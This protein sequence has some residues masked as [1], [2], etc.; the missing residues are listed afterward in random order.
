MPIE[1]APSS[2]VINVSESISR[3]FNQLDVIIDT[4][5]NTTRSSVIKVSNNLIKPTD[6]V[7]SPDLPK[8]M[9]FSSVPVRVSFAFVPINSVI[10]KIPET[11]LN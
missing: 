11:N 10:L 6:K 4:Q 3:T 9:S 1:P 2:K 8:M 7:S 5:G